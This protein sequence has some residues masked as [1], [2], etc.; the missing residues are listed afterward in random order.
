M[1]IIDLT[2]TPSP[3]D[4]QPRPT[5]TQSDDSEDNSE[6]NN[7]LNHS[8]SSVADPRLQMDR[9]TDLKYAMGTEDRRQKLR[10]IEVGATFTLEKPSFFMN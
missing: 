4:G 9:L 8:R 2:C 5:N 7:S 6:A 3:L 10:E 1:Y